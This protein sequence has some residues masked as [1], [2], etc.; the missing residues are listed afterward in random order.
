MIKLTQQD[1]RLGTLSPTLAEFQ[2]EETKMRKQ[3]GDYT[4]L[5]DNEGLVYF[6]KG[7]L[8]REDGPAMI[9]Y[10]GSG[11]YA[12]AGYEFDNKEDWQMIL[13]REKLKALGI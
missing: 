1:K 11:V 2:D 4:I 9:D 10:D 3:D 6:Y 5:T 13:R 7:L 12:L 8:H